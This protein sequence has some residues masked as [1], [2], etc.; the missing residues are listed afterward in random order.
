MTRAILLRAP[1]AATLA[2]LLLALPSMAALDDEDALPLEP[3]RTIEFTV[4][5]GT[6]MS[7][8]VSPD[9]GTI[10][11]DLLGD[12]YT[13]PIAGGEAV[14]LTD[15]MAMDR[16]PRFSPDGERIVFV[17][18]RGG[19]DEVWIMN[20]DGSDPEA[21]TKGDSG[22]YISPT[23]APDGEY[24][25]VARQERGLFKL[26]LYHVDGGT[27]VAMIGGEDNARL[28]TLGPSFT[29][30]GRHVW[31]AHKQGG[32][33]GY[34]MT[35]PQWQL[36]VHD[37]WTGEVFAEGR[38]I[39]S[40]MR[41]LVSPDGRWL[42]YATRHEAQTGLRLRDLRSGE[43]RWLAYPVTR[44]DQE[45]F[46]AL[47][48][49]PGAA[50]LPD[51]SALVTTVDGRLVRIAVPGGD[52][53]PIPFTVSIRRELGPELDF[54]RTLD[55][56]PVIAR[57]IRDPRL[58]PAGDRVAFTAFDMLWVAG[59]DGTGPQR[60]APMAEAAEAHPAWSPDGR[61]IAFVS[62]SDS[63]GGHVWRVRADGSGAAERLSAMPGFYSRPVWS[64][65]GDRLLITRGPVRERLEDSGPGGTGGQA[66]ELHWIP[67]A[68]GDLTFVTHL[69]GDGQP[70]FGADPDRIFRYEG[71]DGLVS[72]RWDGTDRRTHVKVTAASSSGSG[73]PG[74]AD[75]VL[76]APDGRQALAASANQVFLLQVPMVGGEVPTVSLAS[77]AGAPVPVRRLTTTGGEFM[78]WIAGGGDVTGVTWSLGRWLFRYDLAA[79]EAAIA[80]ARE[81]EV[82]AETAGDADAEGE[83]GEE[84]DEPEE[85]DAA[86]EESDGPAYEAAEVEVVVQ[87]PRSLPQGTVL[88]RGGRLVTMKGDEIIGSGDLLI[89]DSRI[90]AVG[91]AGSVDVP[92]GTTVLD[93]TGKTLMPG[94]V[95]VH[96]HY[97]STMGVHRRQVW[98]L[99]ANLA[100][101]V[102]TAHDVQTSTTDF[103]TYRDLVEAGAVIGPRI[104]STGPGVFGSEL[105]EDADDARDVLSRY[106]RYFGLHSIKQYLVGDRKRR[107]WVIEAAREL[108][109]LPTTEGGA[110]LPLMLSHATDGY[111]GV[112]HSFPYPHVYDDLVQFFARAGTVYTPTLIV[113][114]GSPD[115]EKWFHT[116]EPLHDDA[117][118][119]RFTP[120]VEVDAISR[121]GPWFADEEYMVQE[122]AD[123]ARRIIEAG[124]KVGIGGHGQR[125]GLGTHWELWSL[126]SGGL[127][128]HDALRAATI[129]GAEAI[130]LAREIGSLEV[131]KLADVLVLDA[132]P[133]EEIRNSAALR[134]VIRGGRIY[135]ADTLDEV[136]PRQRPL[137]TQ[138]WWRLDPDAD[139]QR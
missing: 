90:A 64:P 24:V 33:G 27:G 18:D 14:S 69:R 31:F 87:Q 122:H 20:A 36:G 40:G 50:F 75:E 89:R 127:P 108:E 134:Y 1:A 98:E 105:I 138:Y 29:P 111:P 55:D 51:S 11:F 60:L 62:W 94:L 99:L 47:D 80:A 115:Y 28:N 46:G 9:G 5:E 124:G 54:Q 114:Y 97:W 128:N 3:A 63:D 66:L 48:L 53:T 120:H 34:N 88:L 37:R 130:G 125:Q 81:H 16:Q 117:K 119:R 19:A 58:S 103:L 110:S 42:V 45:S 118:L 6:W 121:R 95:D 56:G 32:F 38:Q 102:T 74:P 96:S 26:R 67:A 2:I 112:E 113:A 126:A 129:M 23:W 132:D 123:G 91:P 83:E 8:D 49:M 77:P 15:G 72:F 92:E 39:G 57:Q 137:P 73:P 136:W 106:A 44:D 13:L 68:G 104:F 17:S 79:A 70:H 100:Y 116:H 85:G 109:L 30:D 107:Q 43:D 12:L 21:L 84:A 133:L 93:V 61:W 22:P 78:Q 131:G 59:A 71:G 86:T 10:L 7:V 76:M 82:A 135:E 4:D 52:V 41:P 35:L 139:E 101:G 25:A 65:G